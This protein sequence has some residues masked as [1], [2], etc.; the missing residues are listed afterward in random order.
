ME[1]CSQLDPN[2]FSVA[3]TSPW[4]TYKVMVIVNILVLVTMEAVAFFWG[5]IL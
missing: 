1:F 3:K 2:G 5:S 4:R